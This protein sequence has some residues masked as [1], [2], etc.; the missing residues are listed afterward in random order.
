MSAFR[1]DVLAGRV[2]VITGGGSGICFGIARSYIE[3]G[4]RVCITSRKQA[5]LDAA[6]AELGPDVLAVA[7]DVRK[8]EEIQNAV[9]AA[10]ARFGHV[11][12]L[13]NGAAGNFLAPLASL[14]PNGFRTVVDIDL[15]GGF[16]ASKAAFDA[17]RSSGRG[18]VINISATLHLH[19]TPMQGHAAAA[20]AGLDSLTRTQAVE[21]GPLG[22]R[23]VG[24]A[25]GPIG[26]T[27]GMRR[28]APGEMG[29]KLAATIPLGRF[30]TIREIADAAVFLRSEAATY[31]SGIVIVIDGGQSVSV[32]GFVL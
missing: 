27:E 31:I 23:A 15:C 18:L 7:A 8:P 1:D 22:I 11:D 3:H 21:W 16:N 32:P 20:K 2:A 12:T 4:A 5:V 13:I 17:L 9:D 6:A 25:P 30:G 24:I 28:L 26:D 29:A 19:G 10:I 14:S